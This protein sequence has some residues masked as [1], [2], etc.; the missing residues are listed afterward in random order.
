MAMKYSFYDNLYSENKSPPHLG[1]HTNNKYPTFPPIMADGRAVTASYQPEAVT[2]NHLI[3]SNDIKSN[4]EY[5]KYLTDNAVS[6]MNHDFKEAS[7]D[8]G[9][10]RRYADSPMMS[11]Q[12]YINHR[13]PHLYDSVDDSSMPIG[14][15]SSDLKDN[16]L[17]REQLDSKRHAPSITQEEMLVFQR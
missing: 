5:R 11:Q 13:S 8:N 10:I 1:Y 4:W 12:N 6:I 3:E 17:S 7:N 14:H 16:Y 15:S 9:Y 2:N